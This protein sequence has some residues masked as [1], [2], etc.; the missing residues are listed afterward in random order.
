M[1]RRKFE[2]HTR[3]SINKHVEYATV[4]YLPRLRAR[5][6]CL[7]RAR[8][9]RRLSLNRRPKGIRRSGAAERCVDRLFACPFLG[10]TTASR[11]TIISSCV[12]RAPVG[13]RPN[14]VPAHDDRKTRPFEGSVELY[15]WDGTV[16]RESGVSI[17]LLA[18][19]R[20]PVVYT[21]SGLAIGNRSKSS[22]SYYRPEVIHGCWPGAD[23]RW[24][25][26][27]PC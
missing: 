16:R 6:S 25:D 11:A 27:D 13:R 17:A 1:F 15:R 19:D 9:A 26:G 18:I 22:G 3:F 20:S 5:P 24:L 4:R 8:N 2:R 21:L 14:A 10:W 23:R 7:R 12:P